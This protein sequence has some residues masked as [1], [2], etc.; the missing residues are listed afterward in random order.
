MIRSRRAVR[1][2]FAQGAARI[3][4]AE[5]SIQSRIDR[6]EQ[7]ESSKSKNKNKK[8]LTTFHYFAKPFEKKRTNSTNASINNGPVNKHNPSST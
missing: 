4:Q 7:A 5:R 2:R 3:A 6:A 8:P 1:D